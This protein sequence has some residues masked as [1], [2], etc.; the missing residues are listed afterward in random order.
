MLRLRF[1]AYLCEIESKKKKS[2]DFFMYF[3]F[4]HVQCCV[5]VSA[6]NFEV[7]TRKSGGARAFGSLIRFLADPARMVFRM[8]AIRLHR[9]IW[10]QSASDTTVHCVC[11]WYGH[12]TILA[13]HCVCCWY[14]HTTILAG[15][16]VIKRGPKKERMPAKPNVVYCCRLCGKRTE[17]T[18]ALAVVGFDFL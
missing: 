8:P 13:G 4:L 10:V 11:C 7:L 12:T 14:G 18:A 5:R 1:R 9:I 2:W 15:R 17:P 3:F 16:A 6:S